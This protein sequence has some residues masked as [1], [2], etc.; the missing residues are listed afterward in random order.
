M[1]ALAV[2]I[3]NCS[4]LGSWGF[5][6]SV[7]LMVYFQKNCSRVAWKVLASKW[8]RQTLKDVEV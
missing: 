8:I 3:L 6:S 1:A 4:W 2:R 7:P 5:G